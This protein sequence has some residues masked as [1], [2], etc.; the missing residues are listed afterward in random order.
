MHEMCLLFQDSQD[1]LEYSWHS[2]A[3]P[4]KLEDQK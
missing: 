3:L 1:A 4:K 2:A